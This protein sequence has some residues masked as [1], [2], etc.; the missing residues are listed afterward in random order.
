MESEVALVV[1]KG[2]YQG[3]R[4]AGGAARGQR[5]GQRLGHGQLVGGQLGRLGQRRR[6]VQRAAAEQVDRARTGPGRRRQPVLAERGVVLEPLALEQ[7]DLVVRLDAR[8]QFHRPLQAQHRVV[9]RSRQQV[10]DAALG[11]C[12]KQLAGAR[13]QRQRDGA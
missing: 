9:R 5:V 2:P 8:R 1:H 7:Q 6:P 3:R 12:H 13:G 4:Q 11:V 10:R